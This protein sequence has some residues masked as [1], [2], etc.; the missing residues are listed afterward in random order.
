VKHVSQNQPNIVT[1]VLTEAQVLELMAL[2][3]VGLREKAAD[4]NGYRL[5]IRT[6]L[7]VEQCE[8]NPRCEGGEAMINLVRPGRRA[9]RT[10]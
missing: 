2:L 9:A 7:P 8:L 1:L 4:Q 5:A 3:T 10:T 6:N